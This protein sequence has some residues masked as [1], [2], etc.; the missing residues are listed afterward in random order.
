MNT[1]GGRRLKTP[2]EL[3]LELKVQELEYELYTLKRESFADWWAPPMHLPEIIDDSW[4]LV[5]RATINSTIANPAQRHTV[6]RWMS[7]E[8]DTDIYYSYY[9][10]R[11]FKR[12]S[13]YG[14]RIAAYMHEDF[15]HHLAK[16]INEGG[17]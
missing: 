3:A 1:P 15:S 4:Q 16:I 14:T 5:R 9:I 6:I 8:E 17:K 7:D 2:H 11:H 13:D 12:N 10:D